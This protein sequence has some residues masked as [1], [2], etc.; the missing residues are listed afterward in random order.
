VEEQFGIMY[1]EPYKGMLASE[2]IYLFSY[3]LV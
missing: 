2:L 3:G 1:T